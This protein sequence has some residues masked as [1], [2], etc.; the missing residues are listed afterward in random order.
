MTLEVSLETKGWLQTA[1]NLTL[2]A[3]H[4]RAADVFATVVYQHICKF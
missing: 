1:H 2:E 4:M 3:S